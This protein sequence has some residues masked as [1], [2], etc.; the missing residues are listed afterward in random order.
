MPQVECSARLKILF[1]VDAIPRLVVVDPLTSRVLCQD[2][3]SL[4]GVGADGVEAYETL[5]G[6]QRADPRNRAGVDAAS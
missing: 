3:T 5:V 4:F 2:A 1:K 6:M